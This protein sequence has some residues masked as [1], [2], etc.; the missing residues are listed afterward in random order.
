MLSAEFVSSTSG[1]KA[2][3]YSP[4]TLDDDHRFVLYLHGSG[5]FGTGLPGLFQY[6]DLPSLLRDGMELA[7][8]AI[9]PSCHTNTYWQ[10]N[11]ISDFLDDFERDR[12]ITRIKYDVVGYSRGGSGAFHFAAS[13]PKRVRTIAAISA[14]AA[15]EVVTQ[16]AGIP[17]L[18]CHGIMDARVPADESRRMHRS[19]CVA[20]GLCEL[21]LNEG[22]HFISARVLSDNSIFDW[23]KRVASTKGPR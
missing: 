1:M 16:I 13:A 11:D 22:D 12:G 21:S 10:P 6:A 8:T 17:T 9:I 18:L 23:Q 3:V 2:L 19:L 5:G 20:G 4:R 7:S 15:L 14:R